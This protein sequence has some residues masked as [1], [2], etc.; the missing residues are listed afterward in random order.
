MS[1]PRMQEIVRELETASDL[2]IIDTPAALAVS[3]PLPLMRSVTGVVIVARLN[4]STRQTLRRLK[5]LIDSAGGNILGVVATG[6][7]VGLGYQHY[8]PTYYATNGTN[9]T[10]GSKGFDRVRQRLSRDRSVV[11]SPPGS[12]ERARHAAGQRKNPHQHPA[13]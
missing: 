7:T 9:G 12:R 5:N 10:S 2:V 4:S 8:Y 13:D 6:A 1:S 3:D 11:E